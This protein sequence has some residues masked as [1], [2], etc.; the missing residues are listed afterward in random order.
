M[1]MK[2]IQRVVASYAEKLDDLDKARLSFFEE[3]WSEMDRWSGGPLAAVNAYEFPSQDTLIDAWNSDR[4]IFSY[5]TPTLNRERFVAIFNA[6]RNHVKSAEILS[7]EDQQS[8]LDIDSSEVFS[9]T[10]LEQAAKKPESFLD[11]LSDAIQS[12]T[13][14]ESAA[15]I[16]ALLSLLT[17][18]VEF[19]P[20]AQKLAVSFPKG[21]A[22][23]HNPLRCPVCGSAPSL[24]KVGGEGSPTDG[25]G[26]SLYCQQ[27]GTVWDFDRVRCARCGTHNQA[28]LHYFNI[29]GDDGHRIATCDECGN[30][31]RTVFLEESLMPFSFEVEEV[32]TARLDA[33]A[34]D[35]R[36]QAPKSDATDT[37]HAQNKK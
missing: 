14:T 7:Q 16:A 11:E 1:N 20:I 6:L 23:H 33:I 26:R 5:A 15:R 29:E 3:L 32:V 30:Y 25:R 12:R 37:K 31:I 17:L 28:H 13:H 4:A 2:L 27:C 18:R 22:C 24:A 10:L 19:E 21:D 8:L 9:D 36:F 35:P 34:H